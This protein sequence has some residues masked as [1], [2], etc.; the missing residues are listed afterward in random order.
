VTEQQQCEKKG[1][2][3]IGDAG[4]KVVIQKLML[5]ATEDI[6]FILITS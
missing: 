6:S 1:K 5:W 3:G 4:G 2:K